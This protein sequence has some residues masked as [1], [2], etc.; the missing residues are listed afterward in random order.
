MG[1]D[2]SFLESL[3]KTL[4]S[5]YVRKHP[6]VDQDQLA[7]RYVNGRIAIDTLTHIFQDAQVRR[8]FVEIQKS[9]KKVYEQHLEEFLCV[10]ENERYTACMKS[11]KHS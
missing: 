1:L 8:K 5:E 11:I 7:A 3:Q 6:E 2:S 9:Q 4:F 10:D